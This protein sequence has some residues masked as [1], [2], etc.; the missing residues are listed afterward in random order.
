LVAAAQTTWQSHSLML[1]KNRESAG[2]SQT[3]SNWL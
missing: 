2:Q 1:I 3:R